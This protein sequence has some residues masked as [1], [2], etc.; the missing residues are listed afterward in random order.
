MA[1]TCSCAC[2]RASAT[3]AST[4]GSRAGSFL[5][6]LA[7]LGLQQ[8][9]GREQMHSGP[10]TTRKHTPVHATVPHKGDYADICTHTAH[11]YSLC[12]TSPQNQGLA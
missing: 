12:P 9:R 7:L 5:L 10:R 6:G 11:E 4:N 8:G 3:C 1:A 2:P